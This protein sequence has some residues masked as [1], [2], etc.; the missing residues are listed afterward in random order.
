MGTI[1]FTSDTH[2]RHAMVARLRGFADADEHDGELVRRW[3]SVVRPEDVVWHLGDVAL[4]KRGEVWPY[5]DALN[6]TKHLIAGNHDPVW[7]GH[8]ESFK[9][10]REWL[11]HFASVQGFAR[12]KIGAHYALLSHFPYEGD[13][14]ETERYPQ[15]RLP[16]L[17]GWLLHGHTHSGERMT[18]VRL[19]PAMF[20]QTEPSWRGKQISVGLDAWDLKPVPLHEIERLVAAQETELAALAGAVAC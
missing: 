9:H 10:Q 15:Y 8:R 2:F 18:P 13:H 5:V 7:P 1:W 17:G 4:G 20:G 3:N 16:D 19:L 6:G 12:R 14:T 11:G